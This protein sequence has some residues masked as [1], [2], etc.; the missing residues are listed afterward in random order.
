MKLL[1]VTNARIPTE[2]ANGVQ[3][4]KMCEAFQRQGLEVELWL[5]TRKQAPEMKDVENIWTHYEVDTPFKL[6]Y[7]YSP[8][9]IVFERFLPESVLSCLHH[10][11]SLF[12]AVFAL[13]CSCRYRDALYYTRSV[14]VLFALILTKAFHRKTVYFE[15]HEVF[16]DPKRRGFLRQMSSRLM[17]WMLRRSD[18]VIVITQRL[19]ALYREFGLSD[20][21][22]LV[23]PDG[24]DH[25][26]MQV[27]GSKA[28]A[29][30]RLQMA[31]DLKI[32][33]YTGHLY[34]WKGIYTL[35]ES[36]KFLPDDYKIYIVGGTKEDLEALRRFVAEHGIQNVV[37]TGYVPYN[38]VALYLQAA[39]LLVLPNSG[40]AKISSDYTSPLKLFEYMAARRP[41]VAS[42]LPSLREILHHRENAWLVPPDE[43]QAL[44]EGVS[45][46]TQESALADRLQ[47]GAYRDVAQ[48]TWER[49]AEKIKCFVAANPA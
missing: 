36:G 39:D 23:L 19:H 21:D 16:G 49:R 38:Q 17:S 12:F 47:K 30:Q 33:C 37:L 29:R 48:Y 24:I 40:M 42:D 20:R 14:H 11:Q 2:K 8:D 31:K 5:P 25:K 15:A 28:E 13:L 6:R 7:L 22:V 3:I 18:G 10:L 1:Y 43:P 44:A 9:F 46:V 35:A 4:V 45:H 32:V 41:I 34:R 27:F 26:R